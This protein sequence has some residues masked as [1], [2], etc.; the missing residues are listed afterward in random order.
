MRVEPSS[1][2]ILSC[3]WCREVVILFRYSGVVAA[4]ILPTPSKSHGVWWMRKGWCNFSS[5]SI[6]IKKENT[7][8]FR[9]RLECGLDLAGLGSGP[10]TGSW[11]FALCG[12]SGATDSAP[13][14]I[15]F[16]GA[17]QSC[18]QIWRLAFMVLDKH[19]QV[20]N[21]FQQRTVTSFRKY[22]SNVHKLPL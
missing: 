4:Q 3:V 10:V 8:L 5:H 2:N 14:V 6:E 22:S 13:R 9:V 19:Y 12:T 16:R 20:S 11:N 17:R 15:L 1:H 21:W 7:K 18:A